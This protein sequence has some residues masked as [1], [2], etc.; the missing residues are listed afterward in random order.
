MIPESPEKVMDAAIALL[1]CQPN[2]RGM[3][4]V[5]TR[6]RVRVRPLRPPSIG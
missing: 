4:C 3:F 2:V 6:E 1:K 5:V